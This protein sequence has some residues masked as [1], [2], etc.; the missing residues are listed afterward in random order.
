VAPVVPVRLAGWRTDDE[1]AGETTTT[2]EEAKSTA[3]EV[4]DVWA[5][6]V[7]DRGAVYMVIKGGSEADALTKAEVP[8]DIAGTVEIHETVMADEGS[9]T[10]MGEMGS[11]ESTTTTMGDM[12]GG[13]GS[14]TTM[15]EAMQME[16]KPVDKID[17]PAGGTVELKPGGYHVML[18]DVQKTLNPGDTFDVTLTFEKAGTQT[19]TAEVREA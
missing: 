16:M 2:A 13:E 4:S 6:Q 7:Q 19:V 9:S 18:L 3:P 12:A 11:E 14:S 17:I 8:A 10:T 1:T 5:R 15:G